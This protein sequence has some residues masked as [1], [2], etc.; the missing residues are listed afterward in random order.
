MLNSHGFSRVYIQGWNAAGTGKLA[1]ENPYP[2]IDPPSMSESGVW[3]L[4]PLWHRMGGYSREIAGATNY[5]L[6]LSGYF[7][8]MASEF[9]CEASRRYEFY[10]IERD[11]MFLSLNAVMAPDERRYIYFDGS[12]IALSDSEVT[13]FSRKGSAFIQLTP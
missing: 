10:K 6:W 8:Y 12:S 13:V 2:H 9:N 3:M 1:H 5:N 4:N 11:E 7:D